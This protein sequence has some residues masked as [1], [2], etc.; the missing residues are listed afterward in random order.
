VFAGIP[1]GKANPVLN[2]SSSEILFTL[3]SGNVNSKMQES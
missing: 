3:L 2:K 1:A